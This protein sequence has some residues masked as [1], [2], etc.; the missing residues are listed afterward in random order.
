MHVASTSGPSTRGVNYSP[1][2][3]D[4][5]GSQV[6]HIVKCFEIFLLLNIKT[7]ATNFSP[8]EWSY[9]LNQFP[10]IVIFGMKGFYVLA[11]GVIQGH[12]GP[13]V[14]LIHTFSKNK[15]KQKKYDLKMIDTFVNPYF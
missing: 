8:S 2:R 6:L 9:V 7:M 10:R 1:R 3:I 5:Q 12:H 13:L 11:S 14:V 4:C 15:A